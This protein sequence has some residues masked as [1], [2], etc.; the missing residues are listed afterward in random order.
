MHL[1]HGLETSINQYANL[2]KDLTVSG[3]LGEKEAQ[4]LLIK[5]QTEITTVCPF[6]KDAPEPIGLNEK[7]VKSIQ[8]DLYDLECRL[9]L[10]NSDES[11]LNDTDAIVSYLNYKRKRA[12]E[13]LEDAMQKA[14]AIFREAGE[15]QQPEHSFI[16]IRAVEQLSKKPEHIKLPCWFWGKTPVHYDKKVVDRIEELTHCK[17]TIFQRMSEGFIRIATNIRNLNGA[18]AVG[19]YISNESKVAQTILSGNTYFG[20]AFVLNNWYLSIYEPFYLD[21]EIAGI[22]YI[23][24]RESLELMPMRNL[25]NEKVEDVFHQLQ[26]KGAFQSELEDAGTGELIR[27]LSQLPEY[28]LHPV[29]N[30]GLKELSAML[31]KE[32]E[33]KKKATKP[34]GDK[35]ELDFI[36]EYIQEH[37]TEDISVDF[38]TEHLYMSK[39]SLYRYF[40]KNFNTTPRNFINHER[41]KQARELMQYDPNKSVHDISVEVG[42]NHTSYF[43][44]VFK[45]FYGVTPK[46]FQMQL[47]TRKST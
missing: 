27:A 21:D 41:L 13:Y 45:D 43:I 16:Q 5:Y 37:L 44:K 19:T 9:E 39:A 3:K 11:D 29:I 12:M 20:S 26:Q 17:A 23:G 1:T 36:V 15:I 7:S 42:F 30:L 33:R 4:D 25:S 28:A 18:R 32:I 2:L 34:T 46:Q 24:R 8:D 31:I 10:R 40:R 47:K 38:L 6:V 22:L 14:R 35:N